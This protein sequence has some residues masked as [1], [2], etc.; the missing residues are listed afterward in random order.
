M[1]NRKNKIKPIDKVTVTNLDLALRTANINVS[2]HILDKI[3][4][5]VELLEEKGDDTTIRD[6]CKLQNEW[7][8][9]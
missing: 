8:V 5:L 4:D 2:K 3:I 1:S 7:G 6:I 9:E